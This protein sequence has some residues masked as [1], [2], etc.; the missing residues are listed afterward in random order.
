[1]LLGREVVVRVADGDAG[2]L[3]DRA[4]RRLLVPVLGEQA[5]RGVHDEP[6]GLLA[7]RR[8]GCEAV[9]GSRRRGHIADRTW[10]T[11]A[12]R[13][14]WPRRGGP[15]GGGTDRPGAPPSPDTR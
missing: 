2:G 9:T 3:C 4:H 8:N 6:L 13:R 7:P 5:D 12:T 1:M 15:A 11:G 14:R 10:W